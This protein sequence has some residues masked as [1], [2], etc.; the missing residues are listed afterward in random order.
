[1]IND[2]SK[3]PVSQGSGGSVLSSDGASVPLRLACLKHETVLWSNILVNAPV[4]YSVVERRLIYYLTLCIKHK[5]TDMNLGVP[6]S[7][8]DLYFY[9]DDAVLRL[10]G[11]NTHIIQT[12]QALTRIGEKFIPVKF[13][14]KDG[15]CIIGKVHWVDTFFYNAE[16][17]RYVVRISPEI[18]PYLINLTKSF[19]S[20]D[21][22]TALEMPS[23]YSQ[24]LYELCCQFS[25]ELN[26]K[27]R[28]GSRLKHN[29]VPIEIGM[30]RR[31]FNL[32]EEKDAKTGK[33]ISAR[34][35]S[36]FKDVKKR[37]LE[38]AKK[39]IDDLY[40]SGRCNVCF[41]YTVE[42]E[43]RKTTG[44]YLFIYTKD[45]PRKN[46]ENLS[47][48]LLDDKKG[49][50]KKIDLSAWENCSTTQLESV[51]EAFLNRYLESDETWHYL[52]QMHD[53]YYTHDC[54]MQVLRE[55]LQKSQQKKFRAGTKA[56]K[57]KSIMQFVFQ[58]NL[59]QYGWS[60]EPPRK[61]RLKPE[62]RQLTLFG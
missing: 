57:R 32:E 10:I 42:T 26:F 21:V 11:G 61:K 30:L 62:A 5:F 1:M 41:D 8:K 43:G 14:N 55:L 45:N 23:T 7:W 49:S 40:Y 48:Y 38:P 3:A 12:Y 20:F 39:T 50:S 22:A 25:H 52:Q 19:T 35:Y 33:V 29:V 34:K 31:I 56:F 59:K 18:M 46:E 28:F 6:D 4:V 15:Q 60:M 44:I 51:L 54:Y 36:N 47:P 27:D 16:T 24:K 53:K 13:V 37:I 17:N 2:S 9:L 58:D